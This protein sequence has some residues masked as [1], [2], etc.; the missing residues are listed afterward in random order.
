MWLTGNKKKNN[1]DKRVRFKYQAFIEQ[2][3]LKNFTCCISAVL[4]VG[5]VKRSRLSCLK[6]LSDS[7]SRRFRWFWCSMQVIGVAARSGTWDSWRCGHTCYIDWKG[8]PH[9]V[10]VKAMDRGI[11]VSEFVLQLRYYVHFQANT[12]EKGM[13]PLI[14]PAMG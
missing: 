6:V 2:I 14:L 1:S 8:C 4:E 3:V 13:N 7:E 5:V 11:I 12:L 9:G 10:M